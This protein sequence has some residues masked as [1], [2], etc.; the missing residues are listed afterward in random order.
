M[1]FKETIKLSKQA[2]KLA[3]KNP[4]LYNDEEIRYMKMS[5]RA[6]KAGLKRKREMKS[7][8]FKHEL[9]ATSN[10]NT[11]SGEDNGVRGESQQPQQS[12]QS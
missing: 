12:G 11:R 1:R 7:K 8:G 3:K 10:S 2:L 5:L 6:A 4:M 9:S